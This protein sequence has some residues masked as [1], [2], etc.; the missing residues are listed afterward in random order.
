[1]FDP[2]HYGLFFTQLHINTAQSNRKR[3]PFKGAAA[4]LAAMQPT[5]LLDDLIVSGLRYRLDADDAAAR[6]GVERM[7]RESGALGLPADISY[8]DACM[9][10]IGVGHAFEMLRDRF[11]EDVRNKWLAAYDQQAGLLVDAQAGGA[12]LLNTIW[13]GA[14]L[15][16]AG[17]VL[18]RED[19]FNGGI[20]DFTRVIDNEIHPEG[21]L[22]LLVEKSKGGGL[23]RQLLAAKGLALTAEAATHAGHDLWAYE[24]RGISAKTAA[25]YAAA[26]FEYRDKWPWDEPPSPDDNEA[27]FRAN[28]GVFEMLNR[29]L[30]PDVL[31]DTLVK[32]RPVMDVTGGG[33]ITL[34]HG[35]ARRGLFGR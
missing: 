11:P 12:R 31:R 16:V 5:A 23:E 7:L 1:M 33:L 9:Y 19:W 35:V 10:T 22:P 25:I 15:V 20:A 30:R 32:L 26:Y 13:R 28:A 3:E 21:Y 34:T 4:A 6:H 8:I 2:T 17:V 27:M 18:E 14:L 24:V 29:H